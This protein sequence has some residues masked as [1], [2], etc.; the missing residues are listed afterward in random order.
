M[1]KSAAGMAAQSPPGGGAMP[2]DASQG[3]VPFQIGSNFYDEQFFTDTFTLGA[4]GQEF[5]HSVTPGGFLRGVRLQISSSGGVLGGGTLTPDAPWSI[6]S[7]VSLENIDGSPILYPQSGYSYYLVQRFCRPW[8]GNP[9]DR[10]SFSNTINPGFELFIKPEIRDTA[11]CLANTDARAQYRI[12]YTL[13][14]LSALVT[15]GAPT[16]PEVQVIG[17]MKSYAQTD[18]QDLHGNSVQPVPDGLSLAHITRHQILTLNGA[19]STNTLQST[20]TGNELR[21][22]ILVVRD[23]LGARQDYLT[24]PIRQRLDNRSLSVNSPREVFE[25]MFDFYGTEILSN[26]FPRPTGV[27][28][29]PRFIRPG[30]LFGQYWM[31]TSNATYLIYES[32]TLS[33]ATNVPGT[34]EIITDEV[35]P[36]APVPPE[37]EGI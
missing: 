16:P 25:N 28:V 33:T 3:V 31:G 13:A 5:V 14:P 21:A 26:A 11:G 6:I 20:N 12:R 36:V 30:D 22:S 27:Y 4:Q 29:F 7:S 24:D 37:L 34:V 1:V 23:S 2:G 32:Q 9:E 10:D 17:Y 8:E 18:T 35:V 19:A 15:G